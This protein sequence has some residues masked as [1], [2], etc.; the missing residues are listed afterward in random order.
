MVHVNE[1]MARPSDPAVRD[2]SCSAIVVSG[3]SMEPMIKH[4][5]RRIISVSIPVADGDLGYVILKTNA[6]LIKVVHK[7]PSG[8]R[9][10]QSRLSA[11]VRRSH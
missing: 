10:V 4:G 8:W 7:H 6:R 9:V 5:N 11:A 3:D 2:P 1:S